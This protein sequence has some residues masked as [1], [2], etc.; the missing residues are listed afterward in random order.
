MDK[1][2]FTIQVDGGL[3][4]QTLKITKWSEKYHTVVHTNCVLYSVQFLKSLNIFFVLC[5]VTS[6]IKG[7]MF[8][9][10]KFNTDIFELHIK[11][12]YSFN[13]LI[14]FI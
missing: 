5:L 13:N 10:P 3:K 4:C 2:F 14:N 1:Q 12:D 8:P 7:W 9:W 6:S 11:L